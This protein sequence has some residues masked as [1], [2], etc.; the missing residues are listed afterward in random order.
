M[1]IIPF[2]IEHFDAMESDEAT[3]ENRSLYERY[4]D[5]GPSWTI[6]MKDVPVVSGGVVVIWKGVGEAW[7]LLNGDMIFQYPLTVYR[8][9]KTLLDAIIH[10]CKLHR[11][12]TFVL[13]GHPKAHRWIKA[14]GFTSEGKLAGFGPDKKDYWVYGRVPRCLNM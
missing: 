2:K 11:V 4:P 1:K 9:V 6:M 14:L 7:M 10:D 8:V 12:Q 13:D 5:L 3:R